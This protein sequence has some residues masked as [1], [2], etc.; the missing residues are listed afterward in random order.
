MRLFL[1]SIRCSVT[2]T[3]GTQGYELAE[4]EVRISLDEFREQYADPH[5]G[6]E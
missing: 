6:P 3:D 5:G 4:E 2:L 1:R